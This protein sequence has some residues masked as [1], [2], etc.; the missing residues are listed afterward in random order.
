[1]VISQ[2]YF[3]KGKHAFHLILHVGRNGVNTLL[4]TVPNCLLNKVFPCTMATIK[5]AYIPSTTSAEEYLQ[6]LADKI[7]RRK[8]LHEHFYPDYLLMDGRAALDLAEEMINLQEML[9]FF[10]R[11]HYSAQ[12]NWIEF[13]VI[14]QMYLRKRRHILRTASRISRSDFE[15]N[16]LFNK[17]MELEFEAIS[18]PNIQ[19][20]LVEDGHVEYALVICRDKQELLM[21]ICV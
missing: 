11:T 18:E 16:Y 17:R 6:K 5:Y 8:E 4:S 19:I 13:F 9:H 2:V 21:F 20:E 12:S 3:N 1:M 15:F 7:L 10:P 14:T